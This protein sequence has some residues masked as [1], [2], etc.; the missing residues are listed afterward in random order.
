M[1][2]LVKG[3]I[4]AFQTVAGGLLAAL[5]PEGPQ[6]AMELGGKKEGI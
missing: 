4:M 1:E 3:R 5:G 2:C 6:A